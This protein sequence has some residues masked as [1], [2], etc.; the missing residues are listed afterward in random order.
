MVQTLRLSSSCAQ[1]D[2]NVAT[3]QQTVE[4]AIK[5]QAEAQNVALLGA[6]SSSNS[7]TATQIHNEVK[8]AI[9]R[10][11]I[12]NIVNNFNAMQEI[13]LDGNSNIVEDITMEQS[14]EVLYDQSMAALSQ[15]SV[16]Q[17]LKNTAEQVSVAKQTNPISEIISAIGSIISYM[18]TVW[19]II[20]IVI[21]IVGGYLAYSFF[22]GGSGGAPSPMMQLGQ[23]AQQTMNSPMAQQMMSQYAPP[24]A[25]MA[26]QQQQPQTQSQPQSMPAQN[27]EV[28][29][30][31][32][33]YMM[34][35][36]SPSTPSQN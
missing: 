36:I 23:F 7:V 29:Q 15:M 33:R 19:G 3:I 1:D 14:M 26:M 25:R 17:S 5:Q 9:T 18:G 13:W 20:I 32:N 16:M 35:G 4:N 24:Q 34:K 22:T 8:A 30:Y 12:Q 6:A 2:K 11:T 27:M 31:M 10:E 21:V 28:N